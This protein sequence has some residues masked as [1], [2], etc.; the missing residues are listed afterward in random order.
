M[1]GCV[2][3]SFPCVFQYAGYMDSEST[4]S[5]AGLTTKEQWAVEMVMSRYT[6]NS[7]YHAAAFSNLSFIF[8]ET[9]NSYVKDYKSSAKLIQNL[10]I[11]FKYFN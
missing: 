3:V 6:L 5:T 11:A 4:V 9:G 8:A 10:Q 7:I 1:R 2:S